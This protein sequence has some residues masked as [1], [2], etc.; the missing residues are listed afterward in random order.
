LGVLQHV[1]I[2]TAAE[3]AKNML[4]NSHRHYL[5]IQLNFNIAELFPTRNRVQHNFGFFPR[6]TSNP[7]YVICV[8]QSAAT[9]EQIVGV[10]RIFYIILCENAVKFV[11]IYSWLRKLETAL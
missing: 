8:F 11:E 9:E 10:K 4:D 3:K 2:H 7:D 5:L 1:R 6:V